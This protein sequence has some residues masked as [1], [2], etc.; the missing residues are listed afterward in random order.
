QPIVRRSLTVPALNEH[1]RLEIFA[2]AGASRQDLRNV[3]GFLEL[4]LK[5]RDLKDFYVITYY[6]NGARDKVWYRREAI[7]DGGLFYLELSRAAQFRGA[8]LLSVFIEPTVA[9]SKPTELEFKLCQ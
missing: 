7:V 3:R 4:R 8:N 1:Q 2:N 9:W 6:D 5:D